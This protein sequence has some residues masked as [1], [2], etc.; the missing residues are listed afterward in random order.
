MARVQLALEPDCVPPS[1]EGVCTTVFGGIR[2]EYPGDTG[3]DA[4][5][6]PAR[7][8][9]QGIFRRGCGR[10]SRGSILDRLFGRE[11]A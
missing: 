7:S 5:F 4:A 11:G 3:P 2:I 9:T 10:E 6:P 1:L 8:G